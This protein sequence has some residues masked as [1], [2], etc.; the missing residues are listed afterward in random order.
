[1]AALLEIP[2]ILAILVEVLGIIQTVQA[3][4]QNAATKGDVNAV[5]LVAT[6][7]ANAVTNVQW[8]TQALRNLLVDVQSGTAPSL[9]TIASAIAALTPVTLP[10]TPPP[11]YAP[12]AIGEWYAYPLPEANWYDQI[13]DRSFDAFLYDLSCD[14]QGARGGAGWQSKTNPD[15]AL[16]GFSPDNMWGALWG[17]GHLAPIPAPEGTD[18]RLWD[19][20]ETLLAFLQRIHPEFIWEAKSPAGYDLPDMVCGYSPEW[21]PLSWRCLVAESQLP[22]KSGRLW[23]VLTTLSIS[24]PPVWPGYDKVV[25]GTPVELTDSAIITQ[26]MDGFL[27]QVTAN[28]P[29]SGRYGADGTQYTYRGGWVAFQDALGWTEEC[30]YLGWNAG[31]LLPKQMRH[32]GGVCVV[33]RDIQACTVYPFTIP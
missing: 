7:G 3:I 24:V 18:W 1:M 12:P 6:E 23:K 2:E 33:L 10:P 8:G 29:G 15:F 28:K 21:L 25:M 14:I 32:A 22:I 31:I 11:G 30:Q 20:E 4:E 27:M 13:T 19:G 9:A 16:I 26:P 17:E 5:D